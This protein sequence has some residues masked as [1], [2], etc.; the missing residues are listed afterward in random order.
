MTYRCGDLVEVTSKYYP[1]ADKG[2]I[3]TVMH[4]DKFGNITLLLEDGEFSGCMEEVSEEHI[5][6]IDRLDEDELDLLKEEL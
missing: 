5:K 4:V 6:L 1:T 3:A 2:D